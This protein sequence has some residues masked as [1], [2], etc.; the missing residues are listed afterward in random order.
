MSN[1]RGSTVI[2]SEHEGQRYR[3][4][5]GFFRAGRSARY[6]STSSVKPE[7]LSNPSPMTPTGVPHSRGHHAD[8][9]F[10]VP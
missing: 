1:R 8:D 10:A 5:V 4:R 2:A 6:S 9:P 3:A 7:A